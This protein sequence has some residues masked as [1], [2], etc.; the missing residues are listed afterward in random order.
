MY[1][2]RGKTVK[3]AGP[4]IPV[5]ILGFE[6]VPAAGDNLAVVADANEA[7]EI[8]QKRQRLEREAQNRRT[9][10]GGTLEDLSRAMAEGQVGQLRLIIKADQGGPAEALADAL[11]Q[12][13]TDEV[14][15]DVVHRGVGAITESDVLLAKASGAMVLGFHVRPDSNARAAAEREQVDVRTYRIIYEA[16]E[17]VRNALE[18]MLK[19]EE[20]ETVLGD[21]EVLQLFKVSKV[22]TIAGCMVR[23]G[24]IQRTAKARVV[25][26]GVPVYTGNLSSLKR[27]KDDVKEVREGLECGIGIE[28]FNDLKVGDLIESF[29]MEEVKRTL[30]SSATTGAV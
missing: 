16:V 26:D 24:I 1:D 3:E 4:S 22:G 21:A 10:R 7:R 15:V 2:E 13:G 12:L 30:A 17:D 18:G 6:G 20:K 28:N 5:Q 19:P 14:R 11:A 8:A 23:G 25:R 9:S 27:F 29:R